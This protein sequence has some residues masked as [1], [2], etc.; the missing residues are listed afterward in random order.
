MTEYDQ[1]KLASPE[2]YLDDVPELNDDGTCPICDEIED[3][4]GCMI[5]CDGC[6]LRQWECCC[7][8]AYEASL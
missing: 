1:W 7:D 3:E 2:D 8:D 4:C 6:D 5:Y